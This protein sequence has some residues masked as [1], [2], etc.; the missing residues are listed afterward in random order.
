MIQEEIEAV[1]EPEKVLVDKSIE[2]EG[3]EDKDS[4]DM[5]TDGEMRVTRMVAKERMLI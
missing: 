1:Y 5:G 3:D 2:E 4:E